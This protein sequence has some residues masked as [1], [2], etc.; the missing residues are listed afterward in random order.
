MI[1]INMYSYEKMM[2]DLKLATCRVIF[3]KVN[4]EERDMVCTL[5]EDVL[6]P[7]KKDD[8]ISQKKIRE[9]NKEVIAVWDINKEAWRSFRVENVTTFESFTEGKNYAKK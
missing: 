9:L 1:G 3:K 2:E 6:P 8:P 5:K 7:A 4:G